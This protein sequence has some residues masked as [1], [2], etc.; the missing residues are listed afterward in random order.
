[1]KTVLMF[2]VIFLLFLGNATAKSNLNEGKSWE[3]LSQ[4]TFLDKTV[5]E[6]EVKNKECKVNDSLA[7]LGFLFASLNQ[8][9]ERR[10]C[11]SWHGGSCDCSFGRVVCCDG[12]LSPSCGC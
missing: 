9:I 12:T 11:C 10:G 1:M 8:D 7:Y 6:Q 3:M 2:I 4:P 5:T